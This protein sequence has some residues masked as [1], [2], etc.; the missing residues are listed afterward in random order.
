MREIAVGGGDHADVGLQRARAAEALELALL[1][2]AQELRLHGRAHLA[3]LVEEQD[4]AGGQLDLPGLGLVRAGEGAA[5][6]AEQLRLEQLLGQRRAVERDERAAGSRR[7]AVDEPG[8][9]LLAGA[10][11]ARQQ[12]GRLGRGDLRRGLEHRLPG[13]RRSDHAAVP[14]CVAELSDSDWTRASRRGARAV[15]SAACRAVSAS[16]S[17]DTASAT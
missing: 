16:C 9:H 12:H 7:R 5:L 15:A 8:D 11:F 3:D 13:G 4:A 1:Q 10:G 17:C 6:V 2:H 14:D